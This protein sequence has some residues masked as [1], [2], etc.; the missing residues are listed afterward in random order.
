MASELTV[1]ELTRAVE[2]LY[3]VLD[4]NGCDNITLFAVAGHITTL[5]QKI[6]ALESDAQF[7]WKE[8]ADMRAETIKELQ[9][10]LRESLERSAGVAK[11][12]PCSE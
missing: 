7:Y 6:K 9:R 11:E 5:E 4:A 3:K 2:H 8:V 10:K 1:A 12:P